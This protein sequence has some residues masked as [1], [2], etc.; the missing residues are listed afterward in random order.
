M[1]GGG[2]DYISIWGNNVDEI[3]QNCQKNSD[4]DELFS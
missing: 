2:G 1:G 3:T 4:E